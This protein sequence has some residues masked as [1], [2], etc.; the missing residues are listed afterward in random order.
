MGRKPT[1]S[2]GGAEHQPGAE[3]AATSDRDRIVEAF[4]AI[5]AVRP[6]E[7]IGFSEIASRAGV[8]L[9]ALRNQF[10]SKLAILAA[11]IKSVDRKVLEGSDADMADEP[12]RERLFDVL[13]RRMEILAPHKDAIRSLL[14]SAQY[15]PPL[16][17]ALN[18]MSVQSQQ[19]MLTAAD[20]SATGPRGLLRAQGLAVLY[21][22]VLQT[23]VR[24]D[25]PG[26]ARTMAALDNALG[27]GERM[28]DFLDGAARIACLPLRLFG[29]RGR[30]HRP[31]RRGD[32]SDTVIA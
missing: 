22:R 29:F 14:R 23:F 27:R 6:F 12:A 2:P 11:H 16:A 17:L 8:T 13:M 4:L 25:D 15:D 28:A 20:I 24:D 1:T 32:A 18:A 7:D 31:S 3:P 30:S 10:P 5:L 26:H 19:W 21:A 9:G